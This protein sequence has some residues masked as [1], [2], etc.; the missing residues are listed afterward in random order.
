[1]AKYDPVFLMQYFKDL[2]ALHVLRDQL[3]HSIRSVNIEIEHLYRGKSQNPH[4]V[5]PKTAHCG[6]WLFVLAGYAFFGVL[7]SMLY[8]IVGGG[9]LGSVLLAVH[10]ILGSICFACGAS[11]RHIEK[12]RGLAEEAAYRKALDAYAAVEEKNELR[13]KE[14]PLLRCRVVHYEEEISKID[15]LIY[16]AYDIGI[17]PVQYQS[18]NAVAYLYDCFRGSGETD[19]TSALGRFFSE[20]NKARPAQQ[21]AQDAELVLH[22]YL[23]TANQQGEVAMNCR[24]ELENRLKRIEASDEERNVYLE[25]IESSTAAMRYFATVDFLTK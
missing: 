17:L 11:R 14:I 12:A 9:R 22:Q 13:R 5:Q 7:I 3:E 10:L 8:T 16:K 21:T 2:Y 19:L 6:G 1:M 15:D 23:P 20:E 24:R 18:F 4:P 25:M